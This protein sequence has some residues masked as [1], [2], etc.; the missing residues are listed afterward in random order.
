MDFMIDLETLG[1]KENCV[2][3]SIGVVA[4]NEEGFQGRDFYAV[5][6]V[7]E[8]IVKGRKIDY[9]TLKWW[10]SQSEEARKVFTEG[11]H[12][13]ETIL[14]CLT[15]YIN[16]FMEDGKSAFIW[17]NGSIFDISI[18]QN[19]YDQYNIEIPWKFWNVMDLR[20]FV[21]FVGDGERVQNNGIQHN[22]R[23]DARNQAE[24]V[25]RKLRQKC[26]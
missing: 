2:V 9:S 24:Y 21:R 14:N 11:S 23:D 17:G 25:I 19:L 10:M 3:I 15:E 5:F 8:Q 18:M 6:N 22:A 20:T 12:N 26:N 7:E 13:V 4:F 16:S 1:T